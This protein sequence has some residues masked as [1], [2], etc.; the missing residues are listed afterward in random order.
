MNFRNGNFGEINN[1]YLFFAFFDSPL[2][3]NLIKIVIID[4]EKKYV[5]QFL[6]WPLP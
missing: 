2:E 4:F 1:Q 6:V 3:H 5:L